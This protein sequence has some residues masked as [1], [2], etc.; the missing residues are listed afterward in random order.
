LVGNGS[1]LQGK[2]AVITGAG[3][4]VG[5]SMAKLF[6]ERGATIVVVDVIGDRVKQVVEEIGANKHTGMV[7]NLSSRSEAEGM[8][9]QSLRSYGRIDVLCNNAGIMDGV[10][11]VVET[12]DELWE[13]VLNINLNAPFWASRRVIPSMLE[14]GHGVI[15]NTSSVAGIS[16][17]KAG[18]AYTVSKHALIGLTRSIAASYGMKGLR[19]N[20]MV[21]GAVQTAIG[22]GGEPS[23]L[24]LEMMKKATA[25]MPRL[26][27]P[28]EIAKLALYLV[29]DD[30]SYVNGSCVVIDGGWTVS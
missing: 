2:V 12:S 14:K 10:K 6:A 16:G 7:R 5:R 28:I 30:S 1:E 24:G 8:I 23:A 20:A 4:G 9:D 21:L 3:S 27:D 18:A 19:S 26:A 29:S 17:G 15:L 25:G 13:K 22:L 11:P